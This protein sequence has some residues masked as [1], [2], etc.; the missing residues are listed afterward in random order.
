MNVPSLILSVFAVIVTGWLAGA[1]GYLP[2]AL[3]QPLVQF[4]YNVAMPAL[5]F[6]TVAPETISNLLDWRFLAAF[7][8]GI[9]LAFIA[10]LVFARLWLGRGLGESAMLGA[11]V[12]MTNT[13][14]VALPVLQAL[15][16]PRGVLPAA[17]ATVFIAV[18][19]FPV[20][21]VLLEVARG[22]DAGHPGVV[23]LARQVMINPLMIATVAAL[24]WSVLG[25]G[26]PGPVGAYATILG[27]ALTPCALF[28]IGLGLSFEGLGNGVRQTVLITGLK[29]VV[30]PVVVYALCLALGVG[31]FY[32]IAAVVCAAVPTGKTAYV[33]AGAYGVEEKMTGVAISM[34]TLFSIVS[35]MA[36]LYA[37]G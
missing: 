5:I 31:P 8:G 23:T 22:G 29:L 26:L 2:R 1:L 35:L 10:V 9:S 15:Y 7:G 27:E 18:V 4:A 36:W 33:L 12:S 37:L 24:L 3:A 11:V 28:A 16:G 6:V 25:T 32:T 20:L 21:I 19:M 17:I 34:T 30:V 13:G 14:F